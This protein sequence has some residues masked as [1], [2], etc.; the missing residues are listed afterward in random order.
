M[1]QCPQCARAPRLRIQTIAAS[2]PDPPYQA[3]AGGVAE[4]GRKLDSWRRPTNG[5]VDV[6]NR[7]DEFGLSRMKFVASCFP[8]EPW[9]LARRAPIIKFRNAL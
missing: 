1:K 6:L 3:F 9:R 7:L 5:L 4:G 8:S 2:A